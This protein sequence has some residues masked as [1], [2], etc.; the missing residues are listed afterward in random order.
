MIK[1][2]IEV[3]KNNTVGNVIHACMLQLYL[4]AGLKI[5]YKKGEEYVQR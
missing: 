1:I 5:F 3:E 2:T 4:K